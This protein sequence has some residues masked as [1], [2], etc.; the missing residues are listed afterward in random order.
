MSNLNSDD[1]AEE[2][3][4]YKKKKKKM[5]ITAVKL[6]IIVEQVQ[7]FFFFFAMSTIVALMPLLADVIS[8]HRAL[9]SI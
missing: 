7:H 1:I 8:G 5:G 3:V 6:R 4:T 9:F 2:F